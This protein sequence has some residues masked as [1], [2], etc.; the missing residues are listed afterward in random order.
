VIV[1]QSDAANSPVGINATGVGAPL[2]A[3]TTAATVTGATVDATAV[4]VTVAPASGTSPTPTGQV[5][6]SVTGNGLS[7]P[8]T[9]S[10]SLTNGTVTLTLTQL[11][12]GSYQIAVNYIGD[13][14]YAHSSTTLTASVGAGPVTLVQPTAAQVQMDDPGYPYVLAAGAGAQEPY[15]GS[16]T[17]F[18]Y[19]Y[20]VQVVATDG[21]SLIGQPV[22]DSGGKLTGMNYGSVTFQGAPYTAAGVGCAPVPVNSDG[23]APFNTTCF[24]ID[25]TNSAI[26]NIMNS[27]TITPVYSPAGVNGSAGYTNPNYTAVTG[28]PISFTALRNPMVVITASP[29]AMNITAGSSATSTLTLT[30]LLGYGYGGHSSLLNNYSLPVQLECD[31]LPAYATCSFTYPN[32]DSTDAQ[33]VDVGPVTGS[34]VNGATCSAAQGCFGPGTVIMTVTTNVPTGMASLRGDSTGTVFAAMFGLGILTL[35]FGK[36]RSLRGRLLTM[37]CL[38]LICGGV[39]GVNGCSTKQLGVTNG[40]PTPAGTYPVLVTGRQVGSQVIASY[41]YVTYGNRNQVSL[42]FTV[43]V[44]IQ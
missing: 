9:A 28:T 13:K 33:S 18:E 25:T 1:V 27:Y 20:T 30:S 2:A 14:T 38:L 32:P 11:A 35:V 22:Y 4:V 36:R 15:D 5:N 29:S 37:T 41:P 44:T 40:T 6:V 19:T 7:A 8:V 16:V 10:G 31:G 39:A 24:T 3:S 23:T 17:S 26:P 21:A 43:N 34:M 42:P 12:A